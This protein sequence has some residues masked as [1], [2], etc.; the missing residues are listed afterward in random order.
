M[1]YIRCLAAAHQVAVNEKGENAGVGFVQI[2][3]GE[4][5]AD[6]QSC[7]RMFA[8]AVRAWDAIGGTT[9]RSRLTQLTMCCDNKEQEAMILI[10]L[11]KVKAMNDSDIDAAVEKVLFG[12]KAC[13]LDQVPEVHTIAQKEAGILPD[14]SI[15]PFKYTSLGGGFRL[16]FLP[17]WKADPFAR[18][19]LLSHEFLHF[20]IADDSKGV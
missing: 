20:P 2:S 15:K 4:F 3:T 16:S 7:T 11:Q 1:A 8:L 6:Q 19:Q 17:F 13:W 12:T 5:N 14:D 10:E 9:Y 18:I